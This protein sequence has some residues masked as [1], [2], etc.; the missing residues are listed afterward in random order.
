MYDDVD[1]PIAKYR[2]SIQHMAGVAWHQQGF[3]NSSDGTVWMPEL[4]KPI[5]DNVQK[6]MRRAYYASVTWVDEQIGKILKELDALSLTDS[7]IVLF[8]GDHGKSMSGGV[9]R[10]RFCLF[11]F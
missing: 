8:H 7:T 3:F 6:E 5:P 9:V 2:E 10:S 4:D 1:I 11:L